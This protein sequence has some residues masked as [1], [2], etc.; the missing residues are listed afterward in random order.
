MSRIVPA[1]IYITTYSTMALM[2]VVAGEALGYFL[3]VLATT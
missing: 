2:A 1:I 3:A